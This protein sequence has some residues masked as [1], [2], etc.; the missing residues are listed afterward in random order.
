VSQIVQALDYIPFLVIDQDAIDEH[1]L[2]FGTKFESQDKD[3]VEGVVYCAGLQMYK[4]LALYIAFVILLPIAIILCQNALNIS[5]W[6]LYLVLRMSVLGFSQHTG[7]I[8]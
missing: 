1:L 3:F 7:D 4:L 8:V 2:F 6:L 5:L